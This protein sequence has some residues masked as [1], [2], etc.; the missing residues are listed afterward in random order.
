MKLIYLGHSSVLI[1]TKKG[2]RILIDPYNLK[3]TKKFP[4][5]T[6]DIVLISHDHPDHNAGYLVKG[7]PQILKRK[8]NFL[9]SFEIKTSKNE[10]IEFLAIPS[11]HDKQEGKKLG[12]NTIWVFSVDGLKIAHCGDLGH[13]LKEEHTKQMGFIDILIAPIGGGN[14]TIDPKEFLIIMEQS[15]AMISI[16]VHYKTEYTNWITS[17]PDEISFPGKEILSDYTIEINNLPSLPKVFVF[18]PEIWNQ[19]PQ[20]I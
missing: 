17:T 19:I 7:S 6:S 11:F 13:T 1:V 10:I 20:E 18:P 14:Y 12:P 3:V 16:P 2:S 8:T 5:V 15:K 9:S 4:T